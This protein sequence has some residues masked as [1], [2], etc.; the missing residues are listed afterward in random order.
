MV[1][2]R[3]KTGLDYHVV[4]G[5]RKDDPK[6]W[7]MQFSDTGNDAIV[8][9]EFLIDEITTCSGCAYEFEDDIYD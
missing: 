1:F 8:A 2:G 9:Y 7:N 6:Y 5:R 3:F 4:R